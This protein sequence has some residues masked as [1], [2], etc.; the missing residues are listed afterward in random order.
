MLRAP[1]PNPGRTLRE[2]MSRGTVV[3]P[4]FY[5]AITASAAV[6][7]GAQAGY[8]SGAAVTNSQLGVPDIGLVTL[9]EMASQAARIC[10]VASIPIVSDA[11]T[12]FGEAWNVARCVIE[13][14]RAGLAGIHLEDQLMPKK[15]GHLDGKDVVTTEEMVRK[16]K[17]AVAA[18]SK[19][20]FLII[21]RTDARGVEGLD[22]AIDRAK[23][24]VQA[25]ADAIFP[26]GL[27]SENE[28]EAFRSGLEVP[29]LANMTEFG[30]T[31]LIS[32]QRFGELGYEMVIF[33]VSAMRVALKAVT[34]FYGQLLAAG[35]QEGLVESMTTRAE[36]YDLIEYPAYE[37]ADQRWAKGSGNQ[38]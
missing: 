8:I 25:G 26:E 2:L 5:D 1:L 9:D 32:A 17:A 19:S 31:P 12:G 21:A 23:A 38:T 35:T 13:M 11:D 4:G 22:P 28:F 33:P 27:A 36:L 34:T 24:Y 16:L 20:D 7:A 37:A 29:L 3:M 10:Q 15:C 14:E 30:K 18:K 6:R